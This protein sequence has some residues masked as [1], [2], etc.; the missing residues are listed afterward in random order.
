MSYCCRCYASIP[1]GGNECAATPTIKTGECVR[2]MGGSYCQ[3]TCGGDGDCKSELVAGSE[4]NCEI[5]MAGQGTTA[6]CKCYGYQYHTPRYGGINAENVCTATLPGYLGGGSY[7]GIKS[8]LGCIPLDYKTV[9]VWVLGIALGFAAGFA[10]LMIIVSGYGILS[11]QGDPE[12][13]QN[14]K[15]TLT[16][17][18]SGLLFIILSVTIFRLI[19]RTLFSG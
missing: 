9:S 6:Q 1:P 4:Q 7:E 11:S 8:G 19:T 17:A 15:G 14:A 10:V 18:I 16:A 5:G 2:S 3:E 13:L 12:K